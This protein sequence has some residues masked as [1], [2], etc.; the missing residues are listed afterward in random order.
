LV[1]HTPDSHP[2]KANLRAA[3]NAVQEL[4]KF[5]NDTKKDF[6]ALKEMIQSLKM[7]SLS[8]VS[9][10]LLLAALMICVL[11]FSFH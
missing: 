10:F 5:I 11:S 9:L 8:A 1:K 2:D 7:V 3:F 4:A 6:D